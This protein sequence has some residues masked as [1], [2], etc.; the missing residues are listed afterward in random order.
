[1]FLKDHMNNI[2]EFKQYS[3]SVFL[4]EYYR[5][6]VNNLDEEELRT[7]YCQV[8]ELLEII[9]DENYFLY[10]FR[11]IKMKEFRDLTKE[12]YLQYL[13]NSEGIK[14]NIFK[15]GWEEKLEVKYQ[16]DKDVLRY[17]RLS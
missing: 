5:N 11:W 12:I 16:Y 4:P 15:P 9:I 6:Y 13:Y 2:E 14:F 3:N 10:K 8:S 1:M 7:F 17:Y